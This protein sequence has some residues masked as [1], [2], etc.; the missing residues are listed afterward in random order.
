MGT[1]ARGWG[2]GAGSF[3]LANG[4]CGDV[5]SGKGDAAQCLACLYLTEDAAVQIQHQCRRQV[6][7]ERRRHSLEGR[8]VGKFGLAHVRRVVPHT[9]QCQVMPRQHRDQPRC[10][11]RPRGTDH[12]PG[13]PPRSSPQVPQWRRDGPVTIQR[14]ND[15]VEDGGGGGRVVR[16]QP[17]LTNHQTQA[18]L[19]CR[20]HQV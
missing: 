4:V 5:M 8:A 13:P 20:G 9:S 12:D 19:T 7:V 6:E 11:C 1:S 2:A 15:Q 3:Y 17:E 16:R 18:P 14:E 10:S